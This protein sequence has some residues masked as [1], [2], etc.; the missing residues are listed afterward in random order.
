VNFAIRVES[1]PRTIVTD[2]FYGDKCKPS[3]M[4]I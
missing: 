4:Y 3:A 1:Q 2:G